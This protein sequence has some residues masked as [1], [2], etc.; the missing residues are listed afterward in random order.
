MEEVTLKPKVTLKRKGDS[1]DVATFTKLIVQLSW[2][3]EQNADNTGLGPDFDLMAFYKTKD[4]RQG[5]ICAEGYNQNKA[6][7][8]YI[9]K[10]PFMELDKDDKADD[11]SK[12][13]DEASEIL[14]IA[15]LDDFEE[16]YICVIN[17]DDAVENI[18]A[19]F[20][21]YKGY[22]T[23]KSDTG[24]HF[25]VPLDSQESGHVAVICRINNT[26]ARAKL[27]NENMVLSLGKFAR[28]IPGSSLIIN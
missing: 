10:F 22:V 19:V 11:D 26:G 16:V 25:E 2:V 28:D 20:G 14:K 15:K 1:A 18:P 23:V 17:Y 6:D 3:L 5:G 13:G 4:G 27:I 7:M 12:P 9:D 8:G 24:D 21:K